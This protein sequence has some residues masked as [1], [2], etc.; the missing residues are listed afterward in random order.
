[1]SAVQASAPMLS[2]QAHGGAAACD[3]RG[4]RGQA[5]IS[6][7]VVT[8]GKL[9]ARPLWSGLIRPCYASML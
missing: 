5:Q 1:M 7:S 6:L 4:Q 9:C 3:D 2:V 8:D